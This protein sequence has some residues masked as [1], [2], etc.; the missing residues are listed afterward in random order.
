MKGGS[1]KSVVKEIFL[2]NQHV[3][4][5]IFIMVVNSKDR[6]LIDFHLRVFLNAD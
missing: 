1:P 2:I 6:E 3:G 4:R 5:F